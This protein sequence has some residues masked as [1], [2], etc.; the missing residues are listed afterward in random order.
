MLHEN[1]LIMI[2]I[3]MTLLV[4]ILLNYHPLKQTPSFKLI[5][6][7]FIFSA[8]GWISTVLEGL[9]WERYLNVLEHFCYAASAI[10][11]AIWCWIIP[12][13]TGEKA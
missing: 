10:L 6:I 3:G 4:F 11:L 9:F 7:S 1:E 5:F 8:I 13:K 2:V 12:K